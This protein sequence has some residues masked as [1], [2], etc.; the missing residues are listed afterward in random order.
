MTATSLHW[1]ATDVRPLKSRED[2]PL[3]DSKWDAL[4]FNDSC[5]ELS[6]WEPKFYYNVQLARGGSVAASAIVTLVLVAISLYALDSPSRF[7]ATDSVSLLSAVPGAIILLLAVRGS[8]F[9]TVATLGIRILGW[10]VALTVGAFVAATA[11]AQGNE[12]DGTIPLDL[13]DW[14]SR[15]SSAMGVAATFASVVFLYIG[16]FPRPRARRQTSIVVLKSDIALRQ[17]ASYVLG[18]VALAVALG[19][20]LYFAVEI[21]DWR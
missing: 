14:V 16:F 21:S 6:S 10:V 18:S 9:T 1:S 8:Q 20:S 15:S 7:L 17:R 3:Y 19:L 12:E 2:R 4:S 13:L 5:A 11:I